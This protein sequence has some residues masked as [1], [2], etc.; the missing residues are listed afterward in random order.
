[1]LP[2]II[3]DILLILTVASSCFAIGYLL[4]YNV[5]REDEDYDLPPIH[6]DEPIPFEITGARE[7]RQRLINSTTIEK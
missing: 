7:N 2:P 1:M 3:I 5:Q 6:P 4:G